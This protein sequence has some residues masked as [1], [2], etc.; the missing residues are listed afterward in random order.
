MIVAWWSAFTALTAAA[1]NA[2][3]MIAIRTIFGV[4][5]AGAFPIATRS[6]SRWM[7]PSER[8]YAQGITHA[9]SRLGAALTPP[10]VVFLITAYGWRTPFVA[11]GGLGILWS[12]LWFWYYRDSPEEH[13]SVN[14]AE[15]NLIHSASGGPRKRVGSSVP[16]KL[17]FSSGTLWALCAMYFCY[18]Y[19]LAV[20]L[21]WFPTYLKD[22]RGF[23]LKE[24][25]FYASLPLF[26]GVVGDLVGG[27][28]S[29]ILLR[30]GGSVTHARRLVGVT[31]FL[32]AAIG[33]IPATLTTDPKTSVAFSCLAF[34]GLE[35][36][37]GVSWAIPL[38]I[39]GDFAGSA[40]ALMNSVGNIGAAISPA[41]L[42]Y[43]VTGYGWNVPFL[44]AS[45]MCVIG[46][47]IYARIDASR[48]I[49]GL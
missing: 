10:V 40:A 49:T 48:R 47:L 15:R 30:H 29:D 12:L 22:H 46:M 6:L 38:D 33:I 16:W 44:V 32:I 37:V 27:W 36:T 19:A 24:M 9:G 5:E 14:L 35:L 25:G 18:Q 7:L 26:A 31:G 8:G 11:F 4:G 42:A 3:T 45:A 23:T 17:I 39:A 41:V 34:G 2:G 43:L 21:D 28:V 1:W 13:R 20:Y